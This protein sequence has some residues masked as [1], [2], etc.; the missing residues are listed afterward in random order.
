M[1]VI[2]CT[3]RAM[4]TVRERSKLSTARD[5]GGDTLSD[6]L[7]AIINIRVKGM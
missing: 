1:P 2:W 6:T 4:E 3:S 5:P 7:W